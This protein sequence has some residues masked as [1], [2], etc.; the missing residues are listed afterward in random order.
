VD[1]GAP[2]G[3]AVPVALVLTVKRRD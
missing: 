2:G 1:A 3:L